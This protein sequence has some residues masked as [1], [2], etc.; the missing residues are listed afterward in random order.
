MKRLLTLFLIIYCQISA[1]NTSA[2]P[3][4]KMNYQAVARNS[5]GAVIANQLIGLRITVEQGSN[6]TVLY[7]ERDTC[8]TNQFG[9]FAVQIGGGALLAGTYSTIPWAAGGQWLKV[10]MDQAGGSSYTTMGESELLSAPYANVASQSNSPWATSAS[11]IYKTNTGNI[12]IGTTTPTSL[13][14]LS[15]AQ[16]DAKITWTNS[17]N[18]GRLLFSQSGTTFSTVQHVGSTYSN[19]DRQNALEIQNLTGAG[20]ISLWTNGTE[21]MRILGT[22]SVGIGTTAPAYGSKFHV[23]TTVGD[24][25]AVLPASR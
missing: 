9:L 7:Q 22:G 16:P 4:D 17:A 13:L 18:Y 11:N 1:V 5:S 19:A 10:D 3:T 6:G 2:Q 12:G 21:R 20:A 23:Y 24:A 14:E 25:P 15:A 8:T